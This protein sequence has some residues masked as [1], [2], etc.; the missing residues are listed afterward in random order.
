MQGI[1]ASGDNLDRCHNDLGKLFVKIG[2]RP[3]LGGF[4]NLAPVYGAFACLS[5]TAH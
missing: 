4:E 5:T 1:T 2:S 3:A